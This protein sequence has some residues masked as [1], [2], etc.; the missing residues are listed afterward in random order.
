[1]AESGDSFEVVERARGG[2]TA[3][4]SDGQG[5]GRPAQRI[6]SMVV[7]RAAA[8]VADG[9]RDGVVARTV[10]DFLYAHRDGKVLATLT[11]VSADLSSGTIVVSRNSNSPVL[12]LPGGMLTWLDDPVEPIGTRSEMK[13]AIREFPLSPGTLVIAFTD[14]ILNA[15]KARGR[16]FKLEGIQQLLDPSGE[17]GDGNGPSGL[18]DRVL[19]HAIDLDDGRPSDDMSVMVLAV[20]SRQQEKAA[21]GP[22]I[23]RLVFSYPC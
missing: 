6:S 14:G 15:G 5:S 22:K 1:M 23:Q 13:P 10:H 2:V 11:M 3:I 19:G 17:G 9:A 20:D 21:T 16:A 12:V 18:A 8:L 7:N 4:L